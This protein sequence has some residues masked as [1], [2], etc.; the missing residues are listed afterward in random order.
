VNER[1]K[2]E[3]MLLKFKN[4]DYGIDRKDDDGDYY[5]DDYAGE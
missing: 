4:D 5:R 3:F 2:R 1:R